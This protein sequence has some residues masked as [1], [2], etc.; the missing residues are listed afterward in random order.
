MQMQKENPLV[1]IIVPVYNSQAHLA[2][3]IESIERQ[4]VAC[5][6]IILVDDGSTD[7][8]G[9]ICDAFERKYGDIVVIHKEN[10]GPSSARNEGLK[11]AS[12]M[13][14]GF[15]D[16]DDYIEKDMYECL[17]DAMKRERCAIGCCNWLRHIET[18]GGISIKPEEGNI[19]ADYTKMDTNQ[20]LR[21]LLLNQGMTYSP[22]DKL[23]EKS[24]F[25]E[26]QF[27]EE[28]LPSEDI[29]CVY[30]ILSRCENVV[31]IGAPKYYYRLTEG[32]RT[33]KKFA[34]ANMSTHRYMLDIKKDIEER[35]PELN[36]EADF[37]LFQSAASI[38][39]RIVTDE[40]QGEF[41]TERREFES[42]FRKQISRVL[43]NPFLNRNAKM[44]D[45]LLALRL[46]PF[47]LKFLSEK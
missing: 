41:L 5:K 30:A 2:Q 11:N 28:N 31:H 8:S 36:K 20:T 24:L 43:G 27:P 47:L 4:T 32:S 39:N 21:K 14:V 10:G 23:F 7:G 45:V 15:I 19:I 34:K 44:A 16:S 6:E 29:P 38:Y 3:C 46:Y 35:F 9:S 12:G 40:C 26:V 17:L 1:S 37:A 13:Y 42:F 33:Q 22:C 18:Q 25:D